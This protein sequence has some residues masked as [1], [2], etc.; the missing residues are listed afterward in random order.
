MQQHT[1]IRGRTLQRLRAL[2]LSANPLCVRCEKAGRV[3]LATE[4]DHVLALVN[5]GSNDM[6]NMQGLC[7]ACHVD[8][9]IEDLG[10]APKA[11]FGADGRV[12]W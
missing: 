5:G 12:K 3:T 2:V 10:Q 1:R 11:K 4:V 8:K 9:T 6:D 7:Q